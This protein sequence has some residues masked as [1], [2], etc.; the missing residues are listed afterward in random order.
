M[1][2]IGE[3]TRP[4]WISKEG[5]KLQLKTVDEDVPVK[6]QDTMNASARPGKSG[7]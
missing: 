5:M 1:L 7:K 3:M 4:P 6:H 2:S